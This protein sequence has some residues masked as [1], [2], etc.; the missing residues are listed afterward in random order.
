MVIQHTSSL[1]HCELNSHTYSLI[2]C[3]LNSHTSSLNLV[4]TSSLPSTLTL[5]SDIGDLGLGDT[6][7]LID[8]EL[9]S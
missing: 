9:N 5:E 2:H 6:S 7:N 4:S 8:C 3:E 1:I